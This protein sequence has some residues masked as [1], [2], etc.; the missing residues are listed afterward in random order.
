M[1]G[2][3]WIVI[4]IVVAVFTFRETSKLWK[5]DNDEKMD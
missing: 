5:S 2:S 1:V 4:L 3:V